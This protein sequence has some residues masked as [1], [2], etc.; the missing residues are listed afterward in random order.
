MIA[1]DLIGKLSLKASA[2][3]HRRVLE[4]LTLLGAD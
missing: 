2:E 1:N 3:D 4:L